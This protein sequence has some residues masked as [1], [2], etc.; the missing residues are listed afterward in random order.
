M[1][2]CKWILFDF[3]GCLDSDGEH[4]RD[5][6]LSQFKKF[7]II[8]SNEDLKRFQETYSAVDKKVI[9]ESLVKNSLLLHMNEVM[10]KHIAFFL[11]KFDEK[12]INLAAKAITD[13]QSH[14]IKRNKSIIEKLSKQFNLGIISNFSG[15][16]EIILDEFKIKNYFKFVID[17][18]YVGMSKP[19]HRIF[20]LALS[21]CNTPASK[22]CFIGDNL[23]NDIYP[24]KT[25]GMKTILIGKKDLN[26]E[27]D[28]RI[29]S[30]EEL[31]LMTQIK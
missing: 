10:C 27:A 22:T 19:D 23:N 16:L 17:S 12:K 15:N 9:S 4:S 7:N 28:Y 3:G 25:L 2:D 1:K 11:D 21:F 30:L 5:L 31:L 8:E 20:E 6:F 18:Y 29:N 26:L 24:A 13:K 14:Y